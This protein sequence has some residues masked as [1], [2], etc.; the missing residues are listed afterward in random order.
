[1]KKKEK[2][3][4]IVSEGSCEMFHG[5]NKSRS[6][7]LRRDLNVQSENHKEEG[8]QKAGLLS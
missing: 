8:A 6:E 2:Y 1:M 3:K 4:R 7:P 5:W